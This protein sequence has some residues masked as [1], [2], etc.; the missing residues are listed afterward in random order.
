MKLRSHDWFYGRGELSWQHRSA[1]RSMGIDM[2]AYHGQPI[3]GI[4]NSWSELNNCNMSLRELAAEVKAG[5]REAGGIPLEFHTI[6]LGEEL[7]KPSAMLYRN[8]M[9]MDLEEI[10]RANPIDGV[11]MLCNCDKTVPAQLMGA[12]SADLPAIQLNGGPKIAGM[13]KGRKL[14]S[15]TDLWKF[16]DQLRMGEIT[17]EDFKAIEKCLSCSV[18]A[19]N[20]MG[21]AST[22]NAMSEA[23]G[24]MPPGSSTLAVDDPRRPQLARAAGR[25]IVAMIEE[26][27]RPSRLMTA[28]SFDNAVRVLMALGGSTNAIIHLIA[29]AGRLNIDLLLSRFDTISRE[30]PCLANTQPSGEYLIDGFHDAGGVPAIMKRIEGLLDTRSRTMTGS[31]WKEILAE[32]TVHDDD[33]IL[34]FEKPLHRPPTIAI[35]RGNL[36]PDGAA[37][38]VSAA[39]PR[40]LRHTG[41]ALVFRSYEEML[42]RIDDPELPVWED[43]V[44]VLTN[45]GPK[46]VPG[47]PEWGMIPVPKKLQLKGI[48]DVVRV[49][50]SRMS[51]TSYGTVVLHVAPEAAIGG[52][53][54]FVRDGDSISLDVEA[55]RLEIGVEVRAMEQRKA[56]W[57]PPECRHLRGYPRLYY[58][59]VLQAPEGCDFRFLRPRDAASAVFIPPVVG[60]S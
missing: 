11:V 16:A 60:R 41:P 25:R 38:K 24:M 10:L 34:P 56:D 28:A 5:V 49:S 23:L 45:A 36:A 33:I 18:G 52:P 54:A 17:E 42:A 39:S 14:G 12:A 19:C 27:L 48:R 43:S 3:I 31:S 7:M 55:R 53:L 30:V 51:G 1:L 47:M 44:L 35:L 29:I 22:M 37:I 32:I 58:D 50:D 26:D 13:W 20:V 9:S 6:S 59:E 4:A 15:G 2:D 57:R 40:L 21:T 46:G 8:L